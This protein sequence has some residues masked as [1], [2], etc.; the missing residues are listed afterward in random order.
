[1]E[2]RENKKDEMEKMDGVISATEAQDVNNDNSNNATDGKEDVFNITPYQKTPE[3]ESSD[4][5]MTQAKGL[6]KRSI[7]EDNEEPES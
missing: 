5:E 7:E 4:M 2:P 6:G 1:A 3:E